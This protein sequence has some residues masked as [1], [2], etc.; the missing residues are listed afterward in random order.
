MKFDAKNI[1]IGVLLLVILV[2]VIYKGRR[3]S[4]ADEMSPPETPEEAPQE[5]PEEAGTPAPVNVPSDLA[6]SLPSG[7][8]LPKAAD[9]ACQTKY[10]GDWLDFSLTLCKKL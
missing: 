6:A 8:L 7:A 2:L 5:A 9:E 1:I 10:G 4:F 3:I